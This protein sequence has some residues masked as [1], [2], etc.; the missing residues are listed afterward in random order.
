MIH[1]F[2]FCHHCAVY[3]DYVAFLYNF[4]LVS[5]ISN[6]SLRLSLTVRPM[7]AVE[8]CCQRD[9][10]MASRQS[11]SSWLEYDVTRFANATNCDS[12][13]GGIKSSY[14]V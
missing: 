4:Q 13:D 2:I 8:L 3:L 1:S 11:L 6:E 7:V 9:D 14:L 12:D 5:A 10:V